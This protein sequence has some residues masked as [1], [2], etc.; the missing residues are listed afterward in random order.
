VKYIDIPLQHASASVLKRMK[1]GGSGDIFLR[2]LEKIRATVPG[3]TIRT[4]FIAGF[5]GETDADFEELYGFIQAAKF[6]RLGVFSYSDEDAAPS[7]ALDGK[8]DARTIYNRKR[9][10]MSAQKK[11]SRAKNRKLIGREFTVLV[12]GPSAET[13]LLWECRLPGQAPEIDGVC[14]IN[15]FDNV[16]PA[17]G[18]LRRLV[19]TEAHDYDLV[20]TLTHEILAQAPAAATP[21]LFTILTGNRP[22]AARHLHA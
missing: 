20:G 3:V 16:P 6:D 13:E 11:I 15:E 8:V 1:R 2:L 14:Y 22:E 10:L 18:Q 19:V 5:P 9:R 21:D 4:S 7:H 12:E 17:P